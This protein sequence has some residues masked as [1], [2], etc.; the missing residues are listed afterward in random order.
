[1]ARNIIKMWYTGNWAQLPQ[2]WRNQHGA[3]ARDVDH[4]ISSQAYQE[5]L[6]W[7]AIGTHP[8]GAK[9]PGFGTW[10][11]PP[12]IEIDDTLIPARGAS[13]DPC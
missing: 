11:L 10:A 6:V 7:R 9:Q 1:M 4:V 8:Q 3:G 13:K 2:A 12:R 5:G